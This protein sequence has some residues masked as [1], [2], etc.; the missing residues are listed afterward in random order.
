PLFIH[1]ENDKK[2][3]DIKYEY[4]FGRDLLVAPVYENGKDRWKVY[5]PKD[6]WVHLWNGTK[7]NGGEIEV[8]APIGKIPVFYRKSSKYED[9]FKEIAKLS[10]LSKE[11][12]RSGLNR[13]TENLNVKGTVLLTIKNVKRKQKE[14]M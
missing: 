2:T 4:L 6:N 13:L 7:F 9:L 11:I 10:I 14:K 8:E 1:Y 3:Y 5:L 12:K